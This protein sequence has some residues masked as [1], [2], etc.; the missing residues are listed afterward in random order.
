LSCRIFVCC[1]KETFRTTRLI[2]A[3]IACII[4]RIWERR[5]SWSTIGIEL[6]YRLGWVH[7]TYSSWT[8]LI[9]VIY[10]TRLYIKV[11]ALRFASFPSWHTI[12]LIQLYIFI[13]TNS[14]IS[15]TRLTYTNIN[16]LT[17]KIDIL[18]RW[19]RIDC[20]QDKN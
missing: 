15:I 10:L 18:G 2:S 9:L 16:S 7:E 6:T 12:T 20:N 8:W 4:R 3:I 11:V 17:D 13:N 1:L 19:S 5:C 14:T